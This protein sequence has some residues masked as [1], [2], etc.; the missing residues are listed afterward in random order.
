MNAS[1]WHMLLEGA[2]TT[3]WISAVSIAI[4]VMAGL[5]IA[6]IRLARIPIV[7]QL[8][9][10]YISV[11]RAT[12]LVTLALFIFLSAPDLGLDLN[13]SVAGILALTLNTTAFNAEIWRS[14]FRNFSRE[15]SEAAMATG[16]TP[17]VTFRRIMLPQMVI[18][19]LP[20]LVNEMSFLIKGSPAI[21]VIGIVDLTRVT[22]RISAVTYEPL[23]PILVAGVLYMAI[24]GCLVWL[25]RLA[26]RRANRLAT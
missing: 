15:Q 23:P 26:E 12:P 21:A 10:L 4:G 8:L 18:T 24:I 6:L 14:A 25:Q 3:L 1:A 2:W 5:V 17:W 9:V 19:S 22:N 11:A 7:D 20:G 16:M 13:R